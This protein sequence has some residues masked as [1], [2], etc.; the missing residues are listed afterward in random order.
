[1]LDKSAIAYRLQGL[2]KEKG[3]TQK[4]V[5][6]EIGF[7]AKDISLY[8]SGKRI[9][10]SYRVV[11]LAEYYDTTADYILTGATTHGKLP[12]LREENK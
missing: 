2:R 4:R 10:T 5:A 6:K 8:E 9:P 7:V 12:Q 11:K 3:I 1:M